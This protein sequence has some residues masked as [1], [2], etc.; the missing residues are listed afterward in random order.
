MERA[1]NNYF[2]TLNGNISAEINQTV[3]TKAT[4]IKDISSK[5]TKLLI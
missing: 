4:E 1:V 5:I 2:E 3:L